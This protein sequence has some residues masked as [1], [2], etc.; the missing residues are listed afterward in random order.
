MSMIQLSEP[1][2]L[3]EMREAHLA[4]KAK[5]FPIAQEV[6]PTPDATTAPIAAI[7]TVPTDGAILHLSH[8]EYCHILRMRAS[9]EPA[10][11]FTIQNNIKRIIRVVS[12]FY[13]IPT[14]DLIS[15]RRTKGVVRPRQIV[16]YLCRTLTTRSFP[17]I[18]RHL[19]GR[20]HTTILHSFGRITKMRTQDR[21]LDDELTLLEGQ[22]NILIPRREEQ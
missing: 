19:G 10:I 17:E 1:K 21:E 13:D 5:W 18:G 15:D 11:P 9:N 2:T 22:L 16:C 4:R 7:A 14:V 6:S 20:D 3:A 12:D 8:D